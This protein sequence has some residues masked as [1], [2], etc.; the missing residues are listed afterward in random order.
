M[1][2]YTLLADAIV[3]IHLAIVSFVLFGL[4]LILL[5]MCLKWQWIRNFWFRL[6]HVVTIGIVVFE[7]L[8]GIE[9][10]FTTWE[11][12]LRVAA[13]QDVS[14]AS[15]VGQLMNSLLFYDAPEYVFTICYCI[16]GALV[17]VAFVLAPPRWPRK[18][19]TSALLPGGGPHQRPS[20]DVSANGA[21]T[22]VNS[23]ST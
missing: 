13:G 11:N 20:Q 7:S 4:I 14:Q 23:V 21:T 8:A 1:S 12:Q 16:F 10:P 2:W 15:F 6:A 17:L 9:C 5:G 22:P 19:R 3:T 18:R